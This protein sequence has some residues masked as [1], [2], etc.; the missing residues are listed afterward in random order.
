MLLV[1][2]AAGNAA[3]RPATTRVTI[4]T[5]RRMTNLVLPA[6]VPWKLILTTPSRCSEVLEDTWLMYSAASTLPRKACGR[7]LV[8]SPPLKL[9]QSLDDAPGLV[10]GSLLTLVSVSRT[11]ATDSRWSRMSSTRSPCLTS[12]LS[13]GRDALNR[14]VGAAI[15]LD[16]AR[17]V[18]MAIPG[19]GG[20]TGRSCGG[21]GVGI[22]GIA[23]AGKAASSRT[24]LP[25]A[26][27]LLVTAYLLM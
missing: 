3:A 8:G 2:T 18:R 21:V 16:R 9:D 22:L 27:C 11:S 1:P 13:S 5:G 24:E 14:F 7:S 25:L 19:R 6:A 17:H 26:E 15:P 20:K 4:L 23:V 10:D 12:H